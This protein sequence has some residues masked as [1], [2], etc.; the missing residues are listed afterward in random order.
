MDGKKCGYQNI[1]NMEFLILMY[2]LFCSLFLLIAIYFRY[3]LVLRW[4]KSKSILTEYDTLYSTGLWKGM[5]AEMLCCLIAPYPWLG[6][7]TITEYNV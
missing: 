6:N 1:E 4:K 5:A 3:D 7:F 2:N